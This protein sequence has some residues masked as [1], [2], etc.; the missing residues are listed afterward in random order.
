MNE[1][2]NQK[3]LQSKLRAKNYSSPNAYTQTGLDKNLK[4]KLPLWK[5]NI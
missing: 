2:E 4:K 5:L 3:Q 1:Q